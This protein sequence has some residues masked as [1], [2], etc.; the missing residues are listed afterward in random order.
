MVDYDDDMA[1]GGGLETQ[2][3]ANEVKLFNKWWIIPL[4]S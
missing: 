4:E 3:Y 1:Y 2:K